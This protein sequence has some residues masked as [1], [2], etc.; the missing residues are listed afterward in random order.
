MRSHDLGQSRR[1]GQHVQ[2]FMLFGNRK[3]KRKG[4]KDGGIYCLCL[5]WR[6]RRGRPKR[7][8]NKK[9]LV[10]FYMFSLHHLLRLSSLCVARTEYIYTVQSLF[11][12]D[13][14]ERVVN[15]MKRQLKKFVRYRPLYGPVS[16]LSDKS[17]RL[18]GLGWVRNCVHTCDFG[19]KFII[20]AHC[21]LVV[22]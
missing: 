16:D 4:W 14:R 19:N 9:T 6:Q 22:S 13:K 1:T 18:A 17:L 5:S 3:T 20:S 11:K 8:D 15:P 2:L 21:Q 7:D 10:I 12:T